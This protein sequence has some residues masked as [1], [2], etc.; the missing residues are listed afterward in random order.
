MKK[1]FLFEASATLV[2]AV[3]GAGILGIPYVMAQVGFSV[4]I[5]MMFGLAIAMMLRHLML[6]EVTLRTPKIHQMPGYAGIYIGRW[7]KNLSMVIVALGGVGSLLAYALGEGEV[8]SI[9]FGGESLMWSLL[10]YIVSSLFV[11]A[12]LSLIKR[13]ELIMTVFILITT[14]AVGVFAWNNIDFNNILF[15]NISNW[16][17]PYGVFLFALTG[18]VAIPEMREELIGQEAYLS[19]AVILAS[20]VTFVVYLIFSLLVLGVT[21][22]ET[23]KIATVGLGNAVGP[24]MILI[25]NLLAFFTMGT[26]FLTIGLGLKQ[27]MVFDYHWKHLN[28]WLI[29]V[30]APLV[31]FMVGARDFINILGIVG[32]VLAG[33]QSV[34][35]VM[36]FWRS[37]KMGLRK[38]EFTMGSM[39]FSGTVLI[40]LFVM[41]AIF[42]LMNT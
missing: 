4:G 2:G 23:T 38:P 41:G 10:F 34:L 7:A 20:V 30:L 35:I 8:L 16:I 42:T 40:I 15:W 33:I 21:G 17:L 26:S 22:G 28:A 24:E 1:L 5:V 27:V 9:I 14:L 19:K 11:L 37:R 25:G 31:L 13:S 29:I 3:I 12:G 18:S 32:G 6:A 36:V 39:K